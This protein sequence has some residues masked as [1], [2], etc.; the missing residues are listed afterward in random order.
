MQ[1]M[2]SSADGSAKVAPAVPVRFLPEPLRTWSGTRSKYP[3]SATVSALFEEGAKEHP[4]AIALA[5]G[6]VQVT[7][8]E[9]NRRAN[10]LAHRLRHAG[11]KPETMVGCYFER[12]VEMIVA[13]LAVLKAGGA[14][15]PLDPAYPKARLDFILE[16]AGQPV[17]LTRKALVSSVLAQG[18]DRII[19]VDDESVAFSPGSEQ[20]PQL[21]A[22]PTNVAY[23]MY[24]SGSTGRPKGVMVEH[25]G[26]VRLVRDTNYCRFG[27]DE[28]FLQFAPMC[29]DAST[30]EI[31]G[32]LLNGSRLV[33]MPPESSSLEELV[34]AVRK[35]DVTTL[36]LTA[37]LFHL[38]VEEHPEGLRT[39]RQLLAGGDVLSPRHVRLFLEHAPDTCLI[40][41]YGP[42]ENTTFTC[43]H[44]MRTGDP[45][46]ESIPIGKP[47]SNTRVYLLDEN[48]NPVS[49]GEIGE[50][51]AAGDGVARG[52]LNDLDANSGKF[53]TDPFTEEPNHRMYR[54]GDLARWRPDG[55][56]EFL[57]R[58]DSQVKILGYRIEP[59]EIE[60]ALQRHGQVKQACV[61]AQTETA[62]KR[63]VAYFVPSTSG[64]TPEELRDFVAS[65]LPQH[66]VPAFFVALPSLPLSDHGKVDRRAL[67]TLEIAAKERSQAAG[68]PDNQLERALAQ[69]WQRILKV[70]NVGLDDNFFDL[71]G[72]SLLLVAVH[73]NL[74]KLLQT[75]I[76]LTDLFEF[77]TIRKLAQHLGHAESGIAPLSDVQERAQRQ[78]GA[79]TRFRG[80][81][82]GGES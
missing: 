79:F 29:F 37:G 36:W 39:L 42:T 54:T 17:I 31:W 34:R 27:P 18:P 51:Y 82:S 14:Y 56:I 61:V 7:Y 67:A 65:Q 20:N 5:Q 23:V 49:P 1:P 63:L 50:L 73:S 60:T 75:Q 58:M 71:G 11:V 33:L 41:G 38:M 48:M 4:D 15:V 46:P 21:S 25:R 44:T 80:R 64:P 66:M 55:T 2:I 32:A 13:L 53:L 19:L 26:I 12:S 74:Q 22:G 47:I 52:Y 28:I 45:L 10:R 68:L 70:P 59:G 43:C 8:E 3:R 6:E 72:D 76:A 81:R 69:L 77:A 62:G 78:R 9:L 57:G 35:H 40:N 16:D 24:T 30:F